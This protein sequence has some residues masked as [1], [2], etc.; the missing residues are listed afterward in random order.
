L[1][2]RDRLAYVRDREPEPL[3]ASACRR[4]LSPRHAPPLLLA[5]VL[6]L[7][8]AIALRFW[9]LGWGLEQ[10]LPFPDEQLLWIGSAVKFYR[11]SWDSFAVE[12]L[13]YPT[14]YGY[15]AG[16]VTSVVAALGGF[17]ASKP[18][19]LQAILVARIV[20]AAAGVATVA[21]V[22][23]LARR[24]YGDRAGIAAAA[25]CAVFPLEI[26]QVHVA[27]VDVVL[28]LASAATLL[29]SLGLAGR[30]RALRASLAGLTAGFA[31]A[32]KYT[33]AVMLAPV[34]W[35]ILEAAWRDRS[36]RSA[37]QLG[38]AALAGFALAVLL[39]CPYCVFS[40]L[41]LRELGWLRYMNAQAAIAV[42]NAHLA[43][44]LGWYGRPW[45]YQ[46]VASLPYAFGWPLYLLSLLG[47]SDALRSRT[48]A[49]RVL[50]AGIGAAFLVIGSANVT[51][52]R[53]LLP[54]C[55]GLLVL[56]AR[57]GVGT[58]G[59][60]RSAR[61]AALA[62]AWAYALVLAG[63]Q[64]ARTSYDQQLELARWLASARRAQASAVP[65]TVGVPAHTTLY[66][67]LCE[68]LRREGL[69][70]APIEDDA[71]LTTD[72]QVIAIPHWYEIAMRRD[73]PEGPASAALAQIAAG[74]TPFREVRRVDSWF[75][76]QD[77]YRRLDPAFA[78]DL[79]QGSV[80][81]TVYAR[82]AAASALARSRVP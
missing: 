15:L 30:G 13:P 24:A 37:A 12:R 23:L 42:P 43:P 79:A 22:G 40:Q 7:A 56:A 61:G 34:A 3:A 76:Q 10:G 71:W 21:V 57:A 67:R 19:G 20:S 39:A 29:A 32:A 38:G 28:F 14:L 44:S 53:Y 49:D 35:A 4:P 62:A 65:A 16:L 52:P 66:Y 9:R 64:V 81:F 59:G 73:R 82:G 33:G 70:C 48:R 8:T 74:R 18:F 63:T 72:A 46:L 41:M 5:L 77:L 68:T 25:L 1:P 6:V 54:L 47:L 51:Y 36:I 31:F 17:D 11:L 50:L 58:Q 80:G 2:D 45:L 55:P 27:S 78:V 60:V 75:L 26:V 69:D